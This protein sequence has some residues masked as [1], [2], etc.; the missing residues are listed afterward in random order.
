M[1]IGKTQEEKGSGGRRLGQ[2]R[3]DGN[4][5]G[6]DEAQRASWGEGF[7]PRSSSRGLLEKVEGENG[8]EDM[9]R[10]GEAG[11]W[12]LLMKERWEMRY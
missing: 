11:S 2:T 10:H 1:D 3:E 5:L 4:V 12:I 9:E 7:E 8:G 6:F